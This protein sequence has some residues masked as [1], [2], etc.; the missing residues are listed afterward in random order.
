MN[1]ARRMRTWMSRKAA[2]LFGCCRGQTEE[3]SDTD[4]DSSSLSSFSSE[5]EIL[6]GLQDSRELSSDSS[7]TSTTSSSGEMDPYASSFDSPTPDESESLTCVGDLHFVWRYHPDGRKY[8]RYTILFRDL[9]ARLTC[10][11]M[12][13]SPVENVVVFGAKFKLIS[14][15]RSFTTMTY[16]CHR[17]FHPARLCPSPPDGI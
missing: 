12:I 17:V 16:A 2:R 7:T 15:N 9:N 11:T 8:V 6:P 13:G 4:D 3:E 10:I 5:S 1:R 14:T